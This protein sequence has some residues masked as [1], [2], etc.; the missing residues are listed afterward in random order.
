MRLSIITPYYNTLEYTLKLAEVLQP[1]LTEDIEWIIIDDGCNEKELDKLKATV[2]HQKKNSGTASVP[3]NIGLDWATGDY[4]AFI[5]S[6]DMVTDNYIEEILKKIRKQP[7]IIYLSWKSTKHNIIMRQ[8]PPRWNCAVWCRVYK[9]E[10]IGKARFD[11][12]LVKA[13][14]WV[15]NQ[16]INPV[17]CVS[18]KEQIY[19]YT[20]GRKGSICNG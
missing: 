20:Y 13:E 3:R 7:D 5:D 6:D 2:I 10:T 8:R 18:I 17:K 14:D 4:I 1:Q 16:Q 15:F 12:R 11:E 19:I 9:K